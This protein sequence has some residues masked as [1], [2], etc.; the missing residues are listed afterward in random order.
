MY[1]GRVNMLSKEGAMLSLMK[2]L[3]SVKARYLFFLFEFLREGAT[4][5]ARKHGG[6]HRTSSACFAPEEFNENF[7]DSDRERI[8][9]LIQNHLRIFQNR[10]VRARYKKFDEYNLFIIFLT[11]F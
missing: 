2:P 11:E 1:D 8:T 3:P 4:L 5:T 7:A 9:F 6:A 10:M